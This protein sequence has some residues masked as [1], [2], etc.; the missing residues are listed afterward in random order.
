VV[1]PALARIC[2]LRL[3]GDVVVLGRL[4]SIVVLV[5]R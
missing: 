3:F 2:E 1:I 4:V 5:T